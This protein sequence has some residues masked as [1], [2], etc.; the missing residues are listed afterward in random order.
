[1]QAQIFINTALML[2]GRLAP[3][4]AAG[5]SESTTCLQLL[6]A[7]LLSWSSDRFSIYSIASG[8]YALVSAQGSYQ[9]GIGAPDFAVARPVRIETAGILSTNAAGEIVRSPLRI[10]TQFEWSQ[11]PGKG[12]KSSIADILYFDRAAPIALLYLYPI[13][14]FTGAAPQLELGYW[15]PLATFA[16]L[17]TDNTYPDGYERAI[18]Y[19]LAVEIAQLYQEDPKVATVAAP[20]L[21][22][23]TQAV[24]NIQA[25]NASAF[26]MAE[27][28]GK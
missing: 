8:A 17:T 22:I 12:A 26:P 27:G 3:G 4:R 10:I 6:N 21:A 23:A 18:T 13:P 11:I 24:K 5:P 28:E 14:T 9:I 16:T 25:V 7:L 19:S 15:A 2:A 1:M 20:I